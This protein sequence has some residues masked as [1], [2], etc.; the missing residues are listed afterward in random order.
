MQNYP[1]MGQVAYDQ[2]EAG[3]SPPGDAMAAAADAVSTQM[4]EDGI[5]QPIIDSAVGAA[6]EAF[7]GNGGDYAAAAAAGQDA[8]QEQYEGAPDINE[9]GEAAFSA[10]LEAGASPQ[11]AAEMAVA[12]V[13]MA[14]EEAGIPLELLDVGLA[15]ATEAFEAAIVGGA[16][17]QDALGSAMEAGVGAS[18][19]LMEAVGLGDG[20]EGMAGGPEGQEG[21]PEGMP[22]GPGGDG[23]PAMTTGPDGTPMTA[24]AAAATA[25]G[26]AAAW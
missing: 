2:A 23:Q 7:E 20:P 17:P 16:S 9:I 4:S 5:P 10:A 15:A 11:E 14:R 26:A 8:G 19:D 22:G 6:T 1:E 18:V 13:M 21:G 25:D 12:S 3:G 24:E